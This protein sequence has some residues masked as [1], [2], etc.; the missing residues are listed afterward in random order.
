[1]TDVRVPIHVI[2]GFLGSGKTT[3]I[4]RILAHDNSNNTLILINE[5]GEIGLDNL[6]VKPIAD[7]TFLLPSGCMCCAVLS[8]VKETL[9]SITSEVMKGNIQPF[10]KIIIETTGLANPASI[11]ST[12]TQDTH[13]KGM[14]SLH[15]MTCV[16]DGE[17]ALDQADAQP[18]WLTQVVASHQLVLSK[19]DIITAAQAR[20]VKEYIARIHQASWINIDEFVNM[21]LLFATDLSL[22]QQT[23]RFFL[24]SQISRHQS[25]QT[26]VISFY[27]PVDWMRFGLW[28]HLLLHRHGE[29]ILRIKG[30]LYLKDT[31]LPIVLNGVQHC[32]Y[33]PEHLDK[34]LWEDSISRLVFITRDL[35]I[36]QIQKSAQVFMNE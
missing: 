28:L 30:M 4:Q 10:D 34:P 1:M 6:L 31:E 12:L 2:T 16:I 15:G 13:L 22:C 3:F 9:L 7:N 27:Q 17:L 25:V 23:N 5:L 26:G 11:L 8:D 19:K 20:A 24:P 14:F 36:S 33:P 32:L 21:T 18:E 35:P 29:S